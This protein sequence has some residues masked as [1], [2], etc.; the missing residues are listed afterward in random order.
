MPTDVEIS[1]DSPERRFMLRAIE[2][3]RKSVSEPGKVSPKVGAVI[4]RDGEIIG[5]AYRGEIK[6]GE[7]AE[8]T[9]LERKLHDQTLMGATLFT[10]LEPCTSRNHPKIPCA[11]RVAERRI[12][13]VFIGTLDRNVEIRGRGEFYLMDAG[14]DIARFDSDLMSVLEELNR[15]FIRDIRKLSKAGEFSSRETQTSDELGMLDPQ[16][17]GLY[18]QGLRMLPNIHE[19]GFAYFVAH[20]G[21]EISRGLIQRLLSGEDIFIP[22]DEINDQE[23]N[24][25][26][27]AGVLQLPT[28]DPRVDIW[29]QLIRSFATWTH[30]SESGPPPD[31]VKSAF[32]QLSSLLFGQSALI[33][34]LKV[35]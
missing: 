12:A 35:S 21:R 30:Y 2:L 27:I 5:E 34:P 33:L 7:H 1:R 28:A 23:K 10:T 29:F 24:R 18:E 13:K 14:I 6:P 26:T 11:Q 16:L 4:V 32:E 17:A 22:A 8:Y 25:A 19:P 31:A 9:L 20:A 15:D 3:A